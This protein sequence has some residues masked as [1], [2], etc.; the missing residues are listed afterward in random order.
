MAEKKE[1]KDVDYTDHAHKHEERCE[2]CRYFHH[3]YEKCDLVK[4]HI[5]A[6]G[7]CKE[8]VRKNSAKE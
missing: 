5:A 3:L 1:K 8:F 2:L 7:W 6:A 4:G